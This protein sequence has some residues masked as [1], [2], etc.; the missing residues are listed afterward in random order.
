[1]NQTLE[2]LRHNYL[3]LGLLLAF[4]L[5]LN[6]VLQGKLTYFYIVVIFIAAGSLS[7][8]YHIFFKGPVHFEMVKLVTILSSVAYGPY[9]GVLV[10]LVSSLIGRIISGRIDQMA[11]VSIIAIPVIAILASAFRTADITIL[12]IVL[13]LVYT[14]IIFPLVML[15]GGNIGYGII[16]CAT[17][18]F[19]NVILFIYVAPLVKGLI[20]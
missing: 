3:N 10:G 9:T 14:A 20:M 6:I 19:F 17:N 13:V 12:G 15:M 7:T 5:I 18:I 16:Y 1:M 11:I 4:L 8:F 2:K